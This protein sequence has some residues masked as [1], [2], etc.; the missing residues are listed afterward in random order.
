MKVSRAVKCVIEV[1][2][3]SLLPAAGVAV[4]STI[5]AC[6]VLLFGGVAEANFWM[7]PKWTVLAT[8]GICMAYGVADAVERNEFL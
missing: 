7:I 8:I 3:L 2:L 4:V 1:F 6:W 5:L